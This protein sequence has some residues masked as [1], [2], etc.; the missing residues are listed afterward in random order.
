VLQF[1]QRAAKGM[2]MAEFSCL[3][4]AKYFLTLADE[5]IGD[6][7]SN[8]KLQKLVYYAQGFSLALYDKPLFKEHIEAWEHG[9]V[10][11]SLYNKYKAYGANPIPTPKNIDFSK[12]DKQT[13]SLL[14]QIY[15]EYG[16]FSAWKLRDMSHAEE[17]WIKGNARPNKIVTNNDLKGLFATLV[18]DE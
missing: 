9:P 5:D 6:S 4:I 1:I 18:E 11:P 7:I 2:K 17:P 3:D 10:I 8:L 12:Y 15:E 13:K 16:Q 14:N